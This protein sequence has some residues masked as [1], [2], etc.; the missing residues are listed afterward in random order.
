MLDDRFLDK[1]KINNYEWIVDFI[2]NGDKVNNRLA[3]E[4]I[5]DI[6]FYLNKNDKERDM[7]DPELKRAAF[8][9]IQALLDTNA[10][11]LDWEHGWAM[12]KY[13]SPPRTDEEIFEILDKFWYKDDGF[14]LD[15]NYLLFFKR[16]KG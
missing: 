10:V 5:G 11:E 7:Q 3:I 9:V 12:S 14:G 15:K 4:H 1:S 8:T 16:K 6:L 2:L 13:N